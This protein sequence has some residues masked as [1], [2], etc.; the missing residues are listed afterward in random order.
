MNDGPRRL[1]TDEQRARFYAARDRGGLCA[2]C[3]RALDD[4]EPVYIERVLL[5][6]KPL[7][8]AGAGWR[9]GTVRRDAP[10]GAECASSAF[11]ARTRGREPER[12]AGCG[13]P[14]HYAVAREGR[15]RATCS[16]RCGTLVKNAERSAPRAEY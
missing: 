2:A 8:A 16:H 15:Y 4:G 9:R 10:L 11:L 12:C 13:R 7:A 1:T 5:D 6:R 3:G 14:V